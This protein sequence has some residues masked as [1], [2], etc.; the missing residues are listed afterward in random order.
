MNVP[1]VLM[2]K[3]NVEEMLDNFCEEPALASRSAAADRETELN[4]AGK[5]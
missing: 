1:A 5:K 3:V 4:F 2:E